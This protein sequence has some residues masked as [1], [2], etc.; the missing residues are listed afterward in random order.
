MKVLGIIAE[1]NPFHNGHLYHLEESKKL[2]SADYTVCVMSGNFIQRGEPAILDKW[3]RTEMALLSGVDLVI[4]LPVVY[5]MSSAEFFAYG[6]VKILDSL[7]VVD[8]ICFGSETGSI[9]M[10]NKIADVLYNE[11]EDYKLKLKLYL[12]KGLSY[13][14]AREAALKQYFSNITPIYEHISHL[15]N[16]SNSILGIE[17]L[18]AIKRIKSSIVPLT[19]K[20]IKNEYNSQE[21][22]GNISSATA[23]RKHVFHCSQQRSCLNLSQVLP[24]SSLAVLQR[25]FECGRGPVFSKK[26]EDIIIYSLRKMST[27]QIRNLPYV[28]E[29]LENRIKDAARSSG[30]LEDIIEKVITK[31]YTRTRI[32]RSIFSILTG[33]TADEFNLFN[34][35]GGPQYIRVLGFNPKG[36]ELLSVANKRASL[37]IIVKTANFKNSCNPLVRR[38]IEIESFSTGTY[39]LGFNSP[40]LRK[41]GQEFTRNIVKLG[42]VPY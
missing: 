4:E 37:P 33:L 42:V 22:T 25:E 40:M 26:F 29:G 19:I 6:A 17:Y 34:K 27:E 12:A 11:P 31:R 7:G 10:L 38:M 5:A 39:V 32:Q 30:S 28:S 15:M 9:Y 36:R 13:P 16:A 21:I 2:S 23:I 35:Y 18:K 24:A 3:A 8:S 41:S 20:R 14:S 1:Y